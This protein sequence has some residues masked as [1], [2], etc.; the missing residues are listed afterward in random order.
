MAELVGCLQGQDSSSVT[1]PRSALLFL[2]LDRFT[3]PRLALGRSTHPRLTPGSSTHPRLALDRSTHPRLALGRS[4]HSRLALG[5]FTHPRLAL[6]S[7]THPRLALALHILVGLDRF[8]HPRW[9]WAVSHIL[10]WPWAT[11]EALVVFYRLDRFIHN[12]HFK[13]LLLL[14]NSNK[15]EPGVLHPEVLGNLSMKA[16][17]RAGEWHVFGLDLAVT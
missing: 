3:H 12:C 7:S 15:P 10:V 6:G 9:A 1:R 16:Q 8:I 14:L 11:P 13:S 17:P 5:C 4:T 2:A